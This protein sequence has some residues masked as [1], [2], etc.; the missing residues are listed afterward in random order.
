MAL[1]W[2][3]ERKTMKPYASGKYQ[4]VLVQ[5]PSRHRHT[6]KGNRVYEHIYKAEIALGHPLPPQ[7]E[8]HHVNGKRPDNQNANLVI[9]EDHAYHALLH[10]RIRVLQAG[11]NPNTDKICISC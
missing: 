10:R 2:I 8:V 7:A 4:T 1:I 11:G 9:C 5:D 6:M 3:E